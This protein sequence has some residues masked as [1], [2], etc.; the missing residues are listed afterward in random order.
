MYVQGLFV[1]DLALTFST[2]KIYVWVHSSVWLADR[3]VVTLCILSFNFIKL[4][5]LI[6]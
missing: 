3:L 6:V 4:Y 2:R 5:D 1:M